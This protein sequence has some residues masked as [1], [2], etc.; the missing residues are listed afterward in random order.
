MIK[1]ETFYI[2]INIINRISQVIMSTFK[3]K[4]II[5]MLLLAT[6]SL[7]MD[8]AAFHLADI[9][10]RRD[11]EKQKE[12]E[13]RIFYNCIEHLKATLE[14][15]ETMEKLTGYNKKLQME[16]SRGQKLVQRKKN[17]FPLSVF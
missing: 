8:D 3:T 2:D 4:T 15:K 17:A 1:I 13:H 6:L 12:Q 9:D 7:S 11:Q 14:N 10:K 16:L 5:S